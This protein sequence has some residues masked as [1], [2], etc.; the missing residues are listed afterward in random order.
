MRSGAGDH[1]PGSV[2]AKP[3][4]GLVGQAVDQVDADRAEVGCGRRAASMAAAVCATLW[5]RFTALHGGSKSWM[6]TLRRFEAELTSGAHVVPRPRSA[7]PARC[8]IRARARWTGWRLSQRFDQPRPS[9]RRRGSSACRRRGAAAPRG[10]RGRTAARSVRSRGT[11]AVERLR[12]W[13]R[14]RVMMRDAAAVEATG[15]EA[16]RHVHVR[17]TAA[18]D[19][20]LV[21]G[22]G[23]RHVVRFA[24]IAAEVRVRSG[25]SC[26]AD[27]CRRNG[28][29]FRVEAGGGGG[30]A[31][32]CWTAIM[33]PSS[34]RG[35][36]HGVDRRQAPV[37]L[38]PRP[39]CCNARPGHLPAPALQEPPCPSSA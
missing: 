37:R 4:R 11:G 32:R 39:A 21:A 5:W 35:A 31:G 28:D 24:E 8:R 2:L 25:S 6:P 34:P 23:Q 14:S 1:A 19:R 20:V 30:T 12:P 10:G 15:W 7:G 13:P 33:G 18:A 29:Q 3:A 36:W 38:H 9:A 26:N 17:A 27:R 16:E 22:A